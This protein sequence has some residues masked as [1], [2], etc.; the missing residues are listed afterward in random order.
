[1]IG[2]I[3]HFMLI[4]A[5]VAA[6][7]QSAVPLIG[8]G[9]NDSAMMGVGPAAATVQ[10]AAIAIAYGALT[11]AFVVS[12]FTV[13]NVVQNSHSAKPLLYKI[14]GVWG[15]HEGSLLLWIL[16]LALFGS[17]VAW[18]GGALP[19]T[20]RARVLA[21]QG[22]IGVGFL[23]FTIATSNPFG[24]VDPPP[25]D[26]QD[27]NPLLQDPGL[28]F[29]P[30]FLYLGYVG[31]SIAFSFAVAALLEGRVDAAWG[32]WVRPWTLMAWVALTI[33][34]SGG[35]WWAYYELGWGGWWFWDPVENA[36]L[37]PWLTGTALLHSAIVV[38]RR[39]AL[40]SWT[41]LL[42]ILTFALSLLGTFLVRSGVLTSVHAFAL[43]PDRGL[44]IL[45]LMGIA[46]GGSLTLYAL[47][48]PVLEPGGLFAPISREGGLVLNNLLLSTATA[49]V[50]IG[51]LYPLVL[52][53]LGGGRVTVGPPFFNATIIPLAVPL[54]AAMAVA[55]MM[56]WKRADLPGVLGRMKAAAA[57]TIVVALTGA[58]FATGAPVLAAVGLALAFWAILGALVD[59]AG[60]AKLGRIAPADSLRR[61]ANLPG[62]TW[63]SALGHAG[64]GVMILGMTVSTIWQEEISRRVAPGD[65]VSIAGYDITFEGIESGPVANYVTDMAILTVRDGD[66]VIATMTP[67]RRW[68]PVAQMG[69]TQ[70]ALRT[71]LSADLYAVI[72]EG[73]D[74]GRWTLR[75]HHYPLVIWIWLGTLVMVA[76]GICSLA[77]RRLRIAIRSRATERRSGPPGS[78]GP[79]AGPKS[80]AKSGPG[81]PAPQPGE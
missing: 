18:F 75:L 79:K 1:M 27:L 72:G 74:D 30:P 55:P 45:L 68:Y 64:I 5:L 19:E 71:R 48:A 34:I 69:T 63:G 20:L 39:D 51:T 33:G 15:N 4:L 16:I 70:V 44:L 36:S 12:D 24:R 56:A 54:V 37:M 40:K 49:T 17:M 59:L 80:G 47:R 46:V 8:A 11:T 10:L 43:D 81:A 29:H 23:I 14:T 76:G 52:D 3:G 22:M 50:L 21:V 53:V 26:G 9:R 60:R 73:H 66:A 28:A 57:I 32:R 25:I 31:F 42:A 67:E 38:E 2:E 61:L 62:S 58:Y 78:L 6:V 7:V 35:S 13:V 65:T 77:D 41:I